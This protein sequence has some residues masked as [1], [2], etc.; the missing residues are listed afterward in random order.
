[1]SNS[2]P[3]SSLQ[4]AVIGAEWGSVIIYLCFVMVLTHMP[5][6]SVKN[7]AFMQHS[8]M[9]WIEKLIQCA[10]YSVLVA[11]LGCALFPLSKDPV[12]TIENI[13]GLRLALL[14]A[15][16]IGIAVF[17]EFTQPFFGRTKELLDISANICGLL[18]GFC[19]FLVVNEV[20]HKFFNA[21][22]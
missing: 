20:R 13:S 6:D 21:H 3:A 22:H 7:A 18:P 1:M 9:F 12:K 4:R 10:L 19:L 14:V 11:L 2:N 8:M 17:D 5:V 16:V 15:I